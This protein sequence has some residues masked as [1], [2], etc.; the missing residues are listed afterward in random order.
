[1]IC[2]SSIRS[3]FIASLILACSL[4]SF[5]CTEGNSDITSGQTGDGTQVSEITVSII[6]PQSENADVVSAFEL[7]KGQ[8]K[9]LN[10]VIMKDGQP[11]TEYKSVTWNSSNENIC[12]VVPS[13]DNMSCEVAGTVSGNEFIGKMAI[14]SVQVDTGNGI[15]S[16]SVI[17]TAVEVQVQ[18]VE[19]KAD[20]MQ[21]DESGRKTVHVDSGREVQLNAIVSPEDATV[22]DVDWESDDNNVAV[23]GNNGLVSAL[24]P[25]TDEGVRIV[26]KSIANSE[27]YDELYL[28]VNKVYATEIEFD[29]LEMDQVVEIDVNENYFINIYLYP[30]NVT[31]KTVTWTS[32]NPEYISVDNGVVTPEN[33]A[34]DQE[35][36]ITASVP[37]AD[38]SELEFSIKVKVVGLNPDGGHEDFENGGDY[39]GQ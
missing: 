23:V 33:N 35:A 27:V 5:S 10:A 8:S 2:F 16:S 21:T 29:N 26:A 19:I 39:T 30:D 12:S 6:D 38:G 37:Q 15:K 3:K 9:M 25:T 32:S 14:V 34:I 31:E 17:V 18:A 4:L 7:M 28:I 11:Y 1:M 36:D 24:K 20:G 22:K 13:D